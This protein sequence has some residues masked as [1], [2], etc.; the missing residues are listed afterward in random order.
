MKANNFFFVLDLELLFL[1]CFSG[2]GYFSV[3]GPYYYVLC[4]SRECHSSAVHLMYPVNGNLVVEH[5]G[6]PLSTPGSHLV[7]MR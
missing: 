6:G 2:K 4:N 7:I 1:T 3:N 5:D